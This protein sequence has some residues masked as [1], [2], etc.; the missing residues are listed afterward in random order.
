MRLY[1]DGVVVAGAAASGTIATGS[2]PLIIGAADETGTAGKTFHGLIDEVRVFGRGLTSDEVQ[3]LYNAPTIDLTPP[4][5]TA[6]NFA[7]QTSPN[8][9]VMSFSEPVSAAAPSLSVTN[10]TTGMSIDPVSYAFNLGTNTAT[11]AFAAGALADGNYR[12]TLN[13]SMVADNS[14]NHLAS[15]FVLD[16]FSLAGD[17]NHDRTVN[18]LDFNSLATHYGSAGPVSFSDADLNYDGSVNTADF[19]ILAMQFGQSLAAPSPAPAAAEAVAMAPF[20]SP[21]CWSA[22]PQPKDD[23]FDL[24]HDDDDDCGCGCGR[25]A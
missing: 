16:F 9:I 17:A 5:V 14:Q 4:T 8:T 10:L 20:S 1:V 25:G 19:D 18:A 7:Y 13:A 12:A 6:A 23:G 15:N 3:D 24:L 2:E 21:F 11:F 22:V